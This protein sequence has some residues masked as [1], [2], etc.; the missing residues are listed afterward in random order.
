V[1]G[2]LTEPLDTAHQKV[3]ELTPASEKVASI[4]IKEAD[5]RRD[6]TEA[7]KKLTA[8]ADRAR[9]DTAETKRLWKERDELLQTIVR[10]R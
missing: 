1:H 10:L 6:A 7:K 4:Q 5:A 9:L 8:L 3:A 2:W